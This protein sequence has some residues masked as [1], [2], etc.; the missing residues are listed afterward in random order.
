MHFPL[1]WKMF[2]FC[3]CLFVSHATKKH[4][5]VHFNSVRPGSFTRTCK[6]LH[7]T[8]NHKHGCNS[9]C[10]DQLKA[11]VLATNF[12]LCVWPFLFLLFDTKRSVDQTFHVWEQV[13]VAYLFESLFWRFIINYFIDKQPW[14]VD[15]FCHDSSVVIYSPMSIQTCIS[16]FQPQEEKC[17]ILLRLLW[18]SVTNILFSHVAWEKKSHR[19]DTTR[20]WVNKQYFVELY[21][22][23]GS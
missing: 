12:D 8:V 17:E 16:H 18:L 11:E 5:Q 6:P 21:L 4:P 22:I 14:L 3:L 1:T 7:P 20:G 23:C 15:S 13:S 19:F 2:Y 10:K 9:T